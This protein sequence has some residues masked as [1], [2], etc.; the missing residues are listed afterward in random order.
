MKKILEEFIPF[1]HKNLNYVNNSLNLARQQ[2][3]SGTLEG[4]MASAVIYTNLVEYLT[5]NLLE[6]LQHMFFLLSY[7]VFNGIYFIK[8]KDNTKQR[9]PKMLGEII[10]NL[11]SYEFPD[12]PDFFIIL[13]KF[14]HTRNSIFHRLLSTPKEDIEKGEVDK[15][16][17]DLHNL[18]EEVLDKYNSISTGISNTWLTFINQISQPLPNKNENKNQPE[19]AIEE[20]KKKS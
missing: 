4:M 2:K 15:Q 18:A 10:G 9:T 8:N 5:R 20:S 17:S 19:L 6:N 12:S 11:K 7:R 1:E 13:E 3:K 14:S 16:F